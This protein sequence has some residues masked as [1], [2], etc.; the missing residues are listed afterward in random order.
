[1]LYRPPKKDQE[2]AS[3]DQRDTDDS[4]IFDFASGLYTP[5]GYRE[6]KQCE[7]PKPGDSKWLRF[8]TNPKRDWVATIVGILTLVGV[9]LYTYYARQQWCVANQTLKEIQRQA[10]IDQRPWIQVTTPETIPSEV[11]KGKIVPFVIH[12]HALGK[13]PAK[14]IHGEFAAEVVRENEPVTLNYT[15]SLVMDSGIMFPRQD[16]PVRI[17]LYQPVGEKLAGT[18]AEERPLTETE[19]NLLNSGKAE[20]FIY[21]RFKFWDAFGVDHWY[22]FC[23]AQSKR[24]QRTTSDWNAK[25]SCGK[26]NDTDSN[27]SPS[28]K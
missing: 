6:Q 27:Y 13:T 23:I 20:V 25:Q 19:A 1:M 4:Y 2:E 22:R 18:G 12:I 16:D 3:R 14:D 26:Y 15:P 17:T 9:G 10:R 24:Q 8:F 5:K 7:K 11:S 21:G 28:A